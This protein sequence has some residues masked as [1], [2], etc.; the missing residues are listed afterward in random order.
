M[1]AIRYNIILEH[2]NR[3]IRDYYYI[4]VSITSESERAASA[5]PLNTRID[6]PDKPQLNTISS[7]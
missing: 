3:K 4:P 6:K 7:C 1:L 2:L 5:I